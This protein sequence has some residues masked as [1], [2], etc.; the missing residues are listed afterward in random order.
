MTVENQEPGQ[1]ISIRFRFIDVFGWIDNIM[2]GRLRNWR[3]NCFK[4]TLLLEKWPSW[5]V[6]EW[7]IRRN[8]DQSENWFHLNLT[9][10]GSE[11]RDRRQSVYID[12]F[13]TSPFLLVVIFSVQTRFRFAFSFYKSDRWQIGLVKHLFYCYT[14]FFNAI[15]WAVVVGHLERWGLWEEKRNSASCRKYVGV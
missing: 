14:F 2:K 13:W 6:L 12:A 11:W 3:S 8:A 10:H 1:S 5:D 15:A 7:D 4:A 9:K